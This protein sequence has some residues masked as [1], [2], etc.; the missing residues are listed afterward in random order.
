M[1]V[2][3]QPRIYGRPGEADRRRRSRAAGASGGAASRGRKWGLKREGDAE[4][5][6]GPAR[7][8]GRRS[9]GPAAPGGARA[10]GPPARC[11]GAGRSAPPP[12]PPGSGAGAGLRT[13]AVSP[14]WLRSPAGSAGPAS[15]G[16]RRVRLRCPRLRRV[17]PR[18]PLPVSRA[19]RSLIWRPSLLRRARS[20]GRPRPCAGAL[21][22]PAPSPSRPPGTAAPAHAGHLGRT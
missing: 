4:V 19:P 12:G 14:G 8:S 20:R 6:P 9:G 17:R 15:S 1:G 10:R 21:R 5:T 22:A 16:S 13:P 2:R 3:A 7:L 11:W 18:P